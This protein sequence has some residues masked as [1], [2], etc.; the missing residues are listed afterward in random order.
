[1]QTGNGTSRTF[2]P[3]LFV[4]G[5]R[6]HRTVGFF[7][8]ARGQNTNHALMP[9]ALKQ[10]QPGGQIVT[11]IKLLQIPQRL[12][13]HTLF[14]IAAVAVHLIQCVRQ[15]LRARRIIGE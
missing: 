8:D 5:Q 13:L 7:F 14:N 11:G 6:N 4:G 1:M 9:V 12:C 10:H 3:A 2:Q 15:L